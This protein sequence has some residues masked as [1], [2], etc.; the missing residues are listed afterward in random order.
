MIE[1]EVLEK[2]AISNSVALPYGW[3][4]ASLDET[5]EIVMGQSPPSETYNSNAE[6]LPFFQGKAEFG[7]L[8]PTPVK[9]CAK[10]NKIARAGDI[11]I[12]VRAPVGPTNIAREICCIGRGLAAVRP[13][14]GMDSRYFLYYLRYIEP[15]WESQATGSTFSAISGDILRSRSVPL[16]PLNEQRRI[17]A[18]IET[19]FTRLARPG[20][21]ASRQAA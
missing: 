9:W 13:K 10:P 14:V 21:P 4:L 6:G 12:S 11:L 3:Q 17:V 20:R 15:E 16:A 7:S 18:E 1:N 8:Y 19:Q 2:A 5:C